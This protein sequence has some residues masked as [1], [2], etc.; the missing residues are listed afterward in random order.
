MGALLA[1]LAEVIDLSAVTGI[2]VEGILAG[3]AFAT[4][5]VL[6]AQIENITLLEGLT[7]AEAVAELGYAV[8]VFN[9][10]ASVTENFPEVFT[11]LAA[12]EV[13]ANS[14]LVLSA[15][16]AAATYPYSYTN[17]V[18]IANLNNMALQVWQPEI[19]ILFPGISSLARFL[20]YI[21]P[22]NWAG[23]LFRAVGRYFW[24]TAQRSGRNLLEQEIR[25]VG[26]RAAG[27]FSE[28]LARYFEN[29]R[30][31]IRHYPADLY[32]RLQQY[33]TDLPPLNPAQLRELS[34][35]VGGP[36]Q[37]YKLY[38][39]HVK[40][41]EFVTKSPPPGGAHQRT[42]PDWLLPLILGLYGDISPSWADTLEELEEEE[43]GPKKK[44]RASQ[45]SSR[46]AK[47]NN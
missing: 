43:D 3:E 6:A 13:A 46:S 17:E 12:G 21:D 4:A 15:A 24:E 22:T 29:A 23:D 39:S 36:D 7:A 33:Y 18:P 2:S 37:P 14:S 45:R 25:A 20:N 35:R 8:D 44:K 16:V 26:Q 31:A 28:T 47:T 9:A 32:G 10:L 42:T 27:G 30:W 11:L 19:D 34:R 1:V 41:A 38:D 5:E 40:S